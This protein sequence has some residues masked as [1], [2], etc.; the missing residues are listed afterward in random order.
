MIADGFT[1]PMPVNKWAS[2]LDQ[3]GLVEGQK[4]TLKDITLEKMQEQLEDLTLQSQSTSLRS[5][6]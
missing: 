2:F 6:Q 3:L 5:F 4:G 1:K